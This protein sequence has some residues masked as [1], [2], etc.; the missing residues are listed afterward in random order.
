MNNK[1]KT[2]PLLGEPIL[3][4]EGDNIFVIYERAQSG[5][6][7]TFVCPCCHNAFLSSTNDS[8]VKKIK[9]PE[10]ETYICF[11]T[12]GR[13]PT[14]KVRLTRVSPLNNTIRSYSSVFLVWNDGR[15]LQKLLLKAGAITIGR[16]DDKRP[17]DITLDDLTASRRSVKIEIIKGELSG[18]YIFRLTVLRTT[19]AVYVNNNAMYTHDRVYLNIGDVIR[20]G[21]TAFKLVHKED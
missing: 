20:V 2:F 16:K 21:Q 8:S 5:Q 9:C 4:F 12:S 6:I 3:M 11:S 14:T 1:N 18:G 7:Y 17:S 19:N 10:C 15:Q 13:K